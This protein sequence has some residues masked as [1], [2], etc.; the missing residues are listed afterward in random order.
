[1][2]DM[3][4]A[5]DLNLPDNNAKPFYAKRISAAI[6]AFLGWFAL[7]IEFYFHIEEALTRNESVTSHLVQFFSYFTTETNVAITVVA[8]ITA[9]APQAEQ[10]QVRPSLRSALVIYIVVVGLVYA[11]LL[12]HLWHPQ[13]AQ[14]LA[15]IVLHD[16]IPFFYPMFWLAFLP[17][18]SLRWTDP[19]IWLIY[20][21]LFFIYSIA[22]G[23][24]FGI[25]PYPFI[26]AEKLGIE[27]VSLNAL[28]LLAVFFGL[29][30]ILTAVDHALSP[31]ARSRSGLGRAAEL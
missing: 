23:I 24:A 12:R 28:G 3:D 7:G 27:R 15:D 25:Y 21:I 20:P 29:G 14:L 10:I 19:L 31:V 1:M 30:V 9:T 17:K 2:G 8:S 26:D 18:G 11:A 22:R 4:G 5:A 6:I 13:G 16:V